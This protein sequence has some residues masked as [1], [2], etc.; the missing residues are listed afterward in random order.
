MWR[1]E[2]GLEKITYRVAKVAERTF[3]KSVSARYLGRTNGRTLF[4]SK[5]ELD[6]RS[7]TRG[8]QEVIVRPATSSINF[9]NADL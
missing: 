6:Q 5:Y 2:N 7:Q 8:P 3:T 4:F 9:K 1:V